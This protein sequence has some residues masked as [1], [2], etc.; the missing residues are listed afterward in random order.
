MSE[1]LL[2]PK[3]RKRGFEFGLWQA[4][5]AQRAEALLI[6]VLLEGC[7]GVTDRA[8]NLRARIAGHFAEIGADT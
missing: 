8:A 2:G 1:N 3:P 7:T 4:K 6:E 5:R